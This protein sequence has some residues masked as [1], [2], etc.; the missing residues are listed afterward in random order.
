MD[1]LAEIKAGG[2]TPASIE[3]TN[4]CNVDGFDYDNK[5]DGPEPEYLTAKQLAGKLNMSIRSIVKWTAQH[6]IPGAVKMGYHWRYSSTEISK[7]L[8][9]GQLLSP[10]PKR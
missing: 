6:R 10:M 5:L 1:I 9:S 3:G 8:L 4:D 7:R 2:R